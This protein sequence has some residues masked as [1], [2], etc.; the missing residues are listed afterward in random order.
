MFW[1]G[2]LVFGVGLHAC[3]G[4]RS[5]HDLE[6]AALQPFADDPPAAR[7][8]SRATGRICERVLEVGRLDA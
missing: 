6:Q 1:L 7:N 3:I 8:M 2:L 4:R 5:S